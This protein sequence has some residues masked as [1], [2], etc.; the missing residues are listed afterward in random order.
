MDS[1]LYLEI[2]LFAGAI[3]IPLLINLRQSNSHMTD[4]RLFR[5]ILRLSLCAMACDGGYSLVK[6]Q[7]FPG[8]FFLN[9]LF[10]AAYFAFMG[11]TCCSWMMYADYKIYEDNVGLAQRKKWY[12][13]PLL[14]ELVMAFL[15]PVTH[16]FFYVTPDCVYHRGDLFWVHALLGWG[17]M[18][19]AA[20]I[21]LRK[22]LERPNRLKAIE[23][24][25]IIFFML[26]PIIGSLTE[27][28]FFGI[29]LTWPSVS[30]S[31]LV[32]F[33]NIQDQQISLDAL[34]NINNRRRLDKFLTSRLTAPFLDG[35]IYLVIIDVDRFKEINDHYGHAV[36]DSVLIRTAELLKQVCSK[37][38]S[39]D[40]LARYGGDEF[41]IVCQRHSDAEV[42][43]L[44]ESIYELAQVY[45][46]DGLFPCEVTVSAGFAAYDPVSMTS[47]DH[48][49]AAADR[50]MYRI[51]EK[52]HSKA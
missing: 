6:G 42:L 25:N 50:Q 52:H 14:L 18:L 10:N 29:P 19:Y 46:E 5:H 38:S 35:T 48:L 41:A 23:C 37:Q 13:I 15:S 28:L 8:S 34:T 16:W 40:F 7:I 9:V 44:V 51:K 36:G 30:L 32:L 33:L 20:L 49:I 2:N 24:W 45:T 17:M 4:D 26:F 31:I 1:R 12:R 22:L 3:L 39:G 21:A 11:L 47:I 27:T 43:K